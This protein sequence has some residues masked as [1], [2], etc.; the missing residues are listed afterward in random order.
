MLSTTIL[1]ARRVLPPDLITPAEA[2]AAFMND[3]GP[4][5]VPPPA[6]CSLAERILDRLTPE[7]EPRTVERLIADHRAEKEARR[8][9]TE[10]PDRDVINRDV[11]PR[12]PSA[13]DLE[14]TLRSVDGAVKAID[15]R[16]KAAADSASGL[17][18]QPPTFKKVKVADP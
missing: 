18:L 8:A 2:S 4:E 15:L 9:A 1:A 11:A 17:R 6:N 14:R 7:P 3:T 5:A 12:I 16:T 10:S 13:A